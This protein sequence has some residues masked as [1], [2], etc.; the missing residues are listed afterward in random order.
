MG[1]EVNGAQL[2]CNT[3]DSNFGPQCKTDDEACDLGTAAM[4]CYGDPRRAGGEGLNLELAV[5][6]GENV[7]G[8]YKAVYT[9]Y[10]FAKDEEP[11]TYGPVSYIKLRKL[12]R[13]HTGKYGSWVVSPV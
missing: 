1:W 7:A 13:D 8:K 11:V 4:K 2:W 6:R 12:V 5:L 3:S 9:P 10:S